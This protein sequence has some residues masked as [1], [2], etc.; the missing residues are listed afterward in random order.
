[1]SLLFACFAVAS[2]VLLLSCGFLPSCWANRNPVVMRRISVWFSILALCTAIVTAAY[3]CQAGPLSAAIAQS[4]ILGGLSFGVYIDGLAVTM[5]VLIGFIGWIITRFSVRYLDG[6][7]TQ[8]RFMSWISFTLG[9]VLLLVI[10]RNLVMFTA[11]WVLTSFG[12]HQLLTHYRD[13]Q[14]ALLAA[15]KK[16]LIS[17]VG[18][19]LLLIALG[20][21]Y[22]LFGS[23]EYEVIFADAAMLKSGPS[24]QEW[25]VSLIGILYVLVAV[26]KSAQFPLHSWLPDTMETPTPVSAL[27]HAGIINAGGFLVIRLSPMLSMSGFALSLLA[28][29]G[30]TTALYGAVVMLTQTSVKR[31]LAYST[32]AQMGFM[33][34]QCG[35]G[36]Y[37]AALL[38][39]VAHSLY[40]A[41]AF[42]SSGS[43]IETQPRAL[44]TTA[45]GHDPHSVKTLIA[46]AAASAAIIAV[47]AMA[48]SNVLVLNPTSAV[49]MLVLCIALTQLLWTALR[50][51]NVSVAIW[52]LLV[53]LTVSI[54]YF[55]S[56]LISQQILLA[57][58]PYQAAQATVWS[59]VLLA[60][61]GV[62]FIG[63][64]LLQ[65]SIPRHSQSM[66]FKRLYVQV[67]N[68]FYMDIPAHKIVLRLWSRSS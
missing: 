6:E 30:V 24:H 22:Y 68:G 57:S 15:R 44:A 5:M 35:L 43:V 12:L 17:R 4:S 1:M 25:L 39:I 48:F 61:V 64:F 37:S 46:A 67:A 51:S 32:V 3:V 62:G 33:M 11:A 20:L 18:D 34:L 7:P 23:F 14:W 47:V 31:S 45:S 50:L 66:Y 27:M 40:K 10:S 56:Y 26:T 29:F 53:A 60:I 21:T 19:L 36:A 9:A 49:M 41:H 28:L 63:V 65:A 42:L 52:S 58:G 2:P 55:G 13:R 8:G 16:F 38:H 54:A 59:F